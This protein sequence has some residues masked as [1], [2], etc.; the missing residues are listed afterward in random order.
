MSK[1]TPGPWAYQEDSDAYTHIVRGPGN[2]FICQLAQT[3]S[4][5]IEANA[6]LIAAAPELL[7][8][9]ARAL[10][11][12]EQSH[13]EDWLERTCPSGDVESVKRQWL[14]SSDYV[15]FSNVYREELAVLNKI[16]GNT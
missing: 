7:A 5:E 1:H 14:E 4:A 9:V 15:L 11:D 2:R 6:R 3:T 12:G 8:I 10:R 16:E 13:F